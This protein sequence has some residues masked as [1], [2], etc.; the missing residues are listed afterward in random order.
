[1]VYRILQ[2]EPSYVAATSARKLCGLK[3]PRGTKAKE[4]VINYVLDN[5]PEI[6]IQYTKFGNVKPACFDKADSWIVAKAGYT[7]CQ[8]EK[9]LES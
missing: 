8:K 4:V 9:S 5:V 2:T 3:V 6:E 1:M 7:L